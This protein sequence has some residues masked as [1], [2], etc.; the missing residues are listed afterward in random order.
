MALRNVLF[1]T[2]LS[3]EKQSSKYFVCVPQKKENH[4]GTTWGW[5]NH[6]CV[7]YPFKECVLEKVIQGQLQ[8]VVF[9]KVLLH[10]RWDLHSNVT[11]TD[12]PCFVYAL[13]A[14]SLSQFTTTLPHTHNSLQ[15]RDKAGSQMHCC[16][17]LQLQT[18]WISDTFPQIHLRSVLSEVSF[19]QPAGTA[20]PA[21]VSPEK[22]WSPQMYLAGPVSSVRL[23]GEK[24]AE[25]AHAQEV[26][27]HSQ[28]CST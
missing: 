2:P 22:H 16:C 21:F 12:S 17:W 13:S 9:F 11:L 1:W 15:T 6:F 5:V 7:N 19:T 24:H 14:Y 20:V 4:T 25:R 3:F 26:V 8:F 23:P 10:C 18:H 28:Y 27:L